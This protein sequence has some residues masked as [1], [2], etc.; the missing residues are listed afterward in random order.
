MVQ[1]AFISTSNLLLQVYNF[2]AFMRCCFSATKRRRRGALSLGNCSYPVNQ[3]N[4][5]NSNEFYRRLALPVFYSAPVGANLLMM[6]RGRTLRIAEIIGR[7]L[8]RERIIVRSHLPL[9]L[10]VSFVRYRPLRL[11]NS[12]AISGYQHVC[13]ALLFHPPYDLFIY[14][15]WNLHNCIWQASLIKTTYPSLRRNLFSKICC[16]FHA[17]WACHTMWQDVL[18]V[19]CLCRADSG[20]ISE[21]FWNN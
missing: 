4:D 20:P 2:L 5:K 16:V 19:H 11:V 13:A 1:N 10:W 12:I 3:H 17:L 9:S 21:R 15:E 7:L 8:G 14:L 6:G 18:C